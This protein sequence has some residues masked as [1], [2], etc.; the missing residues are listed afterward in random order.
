MLAR[1]NMPIAES[2]GVA[3]GEAIGQVQKFVTE[4]VV[5]MMLE[6]MTKDSGGGRKKRLSYADNVNGVKKGMYEHEMVR[7][8]M[9]VENSCLKA[10]KLQSN[11]D[12][13]AS[14]GNP[15]NS[16]REIY[17][18]SVTPSTTYKLGLL[19]AAK[20][21]S[22][23]G[24][25]AVSLL[26]SDA[27]I[28]NESEIKKAN[29]ELNLLLANIDDMA[30]CTRFGGVQGDD[31]KCDVRMTDDI[32]NH[33]G[34]KQARQLTQQSRVNVLRE[35]FSQQFAMRYQA[36][37]EPSKMEMLVNQVKS[38]LPGGELNQELNIGAGN[39]TPILKEVIGN[40]M[41]TNQLYIQLIFEEETR[42]A[43]AALKVLLDSEQLERMS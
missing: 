36:G 21:Q 1:L 20:K 42:L 14:A 23:I 19:K 26:A 11:N 31:G 38:V 32:S 5:D 9:S 39:E 2:I 17:T 34:Y 33:K 16:S 30:I 13:I 43:L 6:T 41:I 35:V 24:M 4:D 37:G 10:K 12:V 22:E 29:T 25:P 15:F 27:P 7:R 3:I 40:Q 28:H 8:S 18:Q